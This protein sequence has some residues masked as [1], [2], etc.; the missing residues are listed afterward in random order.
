MATKGG[1]E[2]PINGP[3]WWRVHPAAG[4]Q[5]QPGH[6]SV[7]EVTEWLNGTMVPGRDFLIIDVRRSDCEVST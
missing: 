2:H 4:S 3:D 1:P 5:A 7:D 6:V